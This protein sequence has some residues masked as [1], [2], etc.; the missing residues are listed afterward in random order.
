ML[1]IIVDHISPRLSYVANVIKEFRQVDV[2]LIDKKEEVYEGYFY[3]QNL[4]E[5]SIGLHA[6]SLL[7]ESEIKQPVIAKSQWNNEVCLSFN[8]ITDPLASIFYHLTRMEEYISHVPDKHG[9]FQSKDSFVCIY[10]WEKMLLVERWIDVFLNDYETQL[11]TT[12]HRVK[13]PLKFT[14]TFDIDNTFAFRWKPYSRIIGSYIKDIFKGDM[15]RLVAKTK[16]LLHLQKD[17]FDTFSQIYQYAEKGIDIQLFW[18]LGD[19]GEYDRNISSHSK[20]HQQFIQQIDTKILVGLHPSYASNTDDS[21]LQKEKML[22]DKILNRPTIK[23]R[24]HFLKL[25]IPTTY[26]RNIKVNLKEDYTMG[27][28]DQLGFRVGTLRVFDFFDLTTNSQLDFKI[29]PFAYMDG[30]LKEYMNLTVDRSKEAIDSLVQEAK[31]FGGDFIAIWH[32]ETI[33]DWN[34]WKGWSQLIDYTYNKIYE[35]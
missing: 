14:L 19:F 15:K 4:T 29:H 8:G 32:N 25:S 24:Q 20:K 5:S 3:S 27:F 16:T 34:D 2:V 18:L 28:G 12:I 9:R 13:T 26:Q 35:A 23:S 21:L 1:K 17:P 6:A 33:S 31:I 11:N 30:T 10:G 7:F 22:L